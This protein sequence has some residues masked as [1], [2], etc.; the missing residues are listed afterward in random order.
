MADCFSGCANRSKLNVIRG[1]FLRW[2]PIMIPSNG[3][4][5]PS[6]RLVLTEN[7]YLISYLNNDSRYLQKQSQID[8]RKH[9]LA[10]SWIDGD[11]GR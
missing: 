6:A 9:L 11:F 2:T 3:N 4:D 5:G 10:E 8:V 7:R 1:G